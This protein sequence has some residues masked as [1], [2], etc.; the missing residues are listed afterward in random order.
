MLCASV[1]CPRHGLHGPGSAELLCAGWL[2][3]LAP[4]TA[5]L[6]VAAVRLLPAG[7]VLVGW[8]AAQGRPQPSTLK[9]WGAIA[10]FALADAA[11]FQARLRP[12]A[13]HP[14]CNAACAE[15]SQLLHLTTMKG[16]KAQRPAVHFEVGAARFAVQGFLGSA[17]SDAGKL[18]G[19]P[20]LKGDVA[21]AASNVRG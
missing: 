10:L 5:P 19:G 6:W 4:H 11:C 2:Q 15:N 7:V 14:V 13:R 9:A 17:L 16:M 18:L 12:A 3:M 20:V 8:A 21:R 1:G